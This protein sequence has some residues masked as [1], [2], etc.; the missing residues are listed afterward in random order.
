MKTKLVVTEA[1]HNTLAKHLFPGDG[2][3][4]VALVLCNRRWASDEHGL[5]GEKVIVV[6]NEDCAERSA[7]RVANGPLGLICSQLL[8]SLKEKIKR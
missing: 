8:K 6:S 1:Q 7:N 2:K 4:S 5:V 3:E